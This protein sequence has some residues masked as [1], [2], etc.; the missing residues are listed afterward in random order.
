M[1][2]IVISLCTIAAVA[3]IVVG[4]TRS[5]FS[6]TETSTNN[7]IQTGTVDIDIDGQNPWTGKFN[8][9]NVKPGDTKEITFV[10]RNVGAYPV[11]LWKII[12]NLTTEENEIIEPE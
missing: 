1:K 8:W 3:V 2:K 9:E 10:I 4:A 6:D 12:K 5:Y 7:I 11:K